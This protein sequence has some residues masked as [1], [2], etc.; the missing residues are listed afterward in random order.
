[1]PKRKLNFFTIFLGIFAAVNNFFNS[2]FVAAE[3]IKLP[4]YIGNDD[5]WNLD[6]LDGVID[7]QMQRPNLPSNSATNVRVYVIDSK[8]DS[9]HVAFNGPYGNIVETGPTFNYLNVSNIV[10]NGTYYE[11]GIFYGDKFFTGPDDE[12]DYDDK[13]DYNEYKEI[14]LET[15]DQYFNAFDLDDALATMEAEMIEIP[16]PEAER[17]NYVVEQIEEYNHGTMVA[18]AIAGYVSAPIGVV[19][20]LPNLKIISVVYQGLFATDTLVNV[21]HAIKWAIADCLKYNSTNTRCVINLSLGGDKKGMQILEIMAAKHLN[22]LL[23][24]VN[25]IIRV[26]GRTFADAS[27]TRKL[28]ETVHEAAQRGISVAISAGNDGIDACDVFPADAAV[29]FQETATAAPIMVVGSTN[30]YNQISAFS[31]TGQ[32]VTV[33]APGSDV[34]VALP[35]NKVNLQSGTSFATPLVAGVQALCWMKDASMQGFKACIQ[36]S[37]QPA[38]LQVESNPYANNKRAGE[39][40]NIKK[41]CMPR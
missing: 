37:M 13:D 40:L 21:M 12:D 35:D 30:K 11:E 23:N 6:S 34:L 28:T 31:N 27:I 1:M 24:H 32:C 8:V 7:G 16:V 15:A 18:S 25:P 26:W 10:F 41:L 19:G 9:S 29:S 2:L 14:D 17:A 36:E 39:F 20:G 33:Y 5:L 22:K 3:R 4:T 38:T